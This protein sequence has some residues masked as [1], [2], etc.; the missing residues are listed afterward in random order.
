MSYEW[1]FSSHPKPCEHLTASPGTPPA[2][3]EGL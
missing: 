3:G 1:H 2:E